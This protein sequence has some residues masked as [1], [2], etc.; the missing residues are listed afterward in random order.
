MAQ[1]ARELTER[2]WLA[3]AAGRRAMHETITRA[4]PCDGS[5]LYAVAVAGAFAD[6]CAAST[7]PGEREL[8]AVINAQLAQAG[9]HLA[10]L[11]RN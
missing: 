8:V 6:L 2:Q 7:A 3:V 1:A 9:L 10:P 4:Y 11:R 5:A